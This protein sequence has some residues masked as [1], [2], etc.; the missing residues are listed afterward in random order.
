MGNVADP[1]ACG[2]VVGFLVGVVVTDGVGVTVGLKVVSA[3]MG[4]DSVSLTR[5]AQ[6]LPSEL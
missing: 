5:V 1:V 4:Q 3:A 6:D 2:V